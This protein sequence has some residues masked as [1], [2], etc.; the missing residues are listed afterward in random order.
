VFNLLVKYT[1]WADGRDTLPRSRA[2]EHT[3]KT[4]VH[5]F[6]PSAQLDLTALAALPTLFMQ[7]TSGQ[8]DQV[9]RVGNIT[10][11]R[12]SGRDIV[13]EYTYDLGIPAF[14][15]SALQNFSADL[16]IED[17]EFARTHWAVKDNDLYRVLLKNFQPRRRR[18]SVF[19]LTEYESIE[20]SL[21]SVM[22][23][24]D[25]RFDAV[26]ACLKQTAEA[27]GLR[28]RRADDIWENPAVIQDVLSLI[29]R[30]SIIICDC[31]PKS[32]RLL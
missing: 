31:R 6:E 17:F 4:L 28:C 11:A 24:F 32:Q 21:V 7:E 5:R 10:R 12:I 22:M 9:A 23:P 30:S 13:L 3:E 19:H 18:P 14:P 27:V 29:D 15:N 1:P 8:R 20:A 25:A 26:Y 2:L 16:D